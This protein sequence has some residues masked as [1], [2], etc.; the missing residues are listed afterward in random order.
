MIVPGIIAMNQEE[1]DEMLENVPDN[2]GR[3]ML[4]VMDGRFVPNRS[5]DFRIS[6]PDDRDLEYEAHLMVE[7]PFNW[8]ETNMNKVDIAVLHVETL[9]DIGSSI[10]RAKEMG[11]NVTLAMSP[12]TD[13]D[14]VV[15]YLNEVKTV[16]VL[17]VEPGQYGAPF[18]PQALEKVKE[19][20]R[21]N[22]SIPIEV[23][24]AMNPMNI[25]LAKEAGA[26][27]FASGSYVMKSKSPKRAIEE[28]E[29]ALND[30]L[31]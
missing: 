12:Q 2:V 3:V 19:L 16:L 21:I 11:L 5:L 10:R 8:L 6:I 30:K 9:S 29:N 20:R 18:V 15:P 26:T 23:D 25:K 4:D 22:Q 27:I 17:T 7:D 14:I 31:V 13:L 24:G 28:L 1:L